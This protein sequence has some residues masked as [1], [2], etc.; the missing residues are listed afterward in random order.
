VSSR[1]FT[2]DSSSSSSS[3]SSV[4][5]EPSVRGKILNQSTMKEKKVVLVEDE[6]DII[7]TFKVALESA[8]FIV[9]AYQDPLTALS[10]FKSC[11]YDL[12]ILDIKMPQ[13]NGFELYTEMRKIDEQV[14]VCFI[15]AGEMYFDKFRRQKGEERE[16][17]GVEEQ[18]CEL[19]SERFL[20]KPISNEDLVKRINKIMMLK[21][22]PDILQNT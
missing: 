15:T 3:S 1:D 11:Y 17:Q 21:K 2:S 19:N 12:V 4:A 6:P 18:Y 16:G 8:G 10:E 7:M 14:R 5:I 13:M 9:Y 20:Q 22:D